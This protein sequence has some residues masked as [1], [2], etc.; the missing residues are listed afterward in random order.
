MGF[1]VH[2]L[3][4]E[5]RLSAGDYDAFVGDC[6]SVLGAW[7][8]H[9]LSP[10]DLNAAD[11][12]HDWVLLD[13]TDERAGGGKGVQVF[14]SLQRNTHTKKYGRGR[15][16]VF[17]EVYTETKAGRSIWSL[18]VQLMIPLKAF[19]RFPEVIVVA[20]PERT[21]LHPKNYQSFIMGELES[22]FGADEA[23]K[24]SPLISAAAAPNNGMHPTA[25]TND[26]M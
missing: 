25:D 16:K 12:V 14:V 20:D 7:R 2:I 18:A 3:L 22:W 23:E 13:P 8:V 4:T 1:G 11:I 15:R 21:F 24:I 17:W 19:E 26:F 6:S 5:K 10:F 9:E